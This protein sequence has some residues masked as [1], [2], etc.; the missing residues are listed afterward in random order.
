MPGGNI[1]KILL[2]GPYPPPHGGV[3]VHVYEARRQLRLA[4][5]ECRVVNV[6]P[7]APQS[8]DYV[9]IRGGL[10]LLFLLTRFARNGWT[11]HAHTN[12]HNRKSWLVALIAG[13][14]GRLGPGSLLTLHSGLAPAYIAKGRV[15]PR[16]LARSVCLLYRR[17]IAVAPEVRE[18]VLSLGLPAGRVGV[19]PAFLFTAPSG[20]EAPELQEVEGRKPL[21][22]ATLSFRPEYGFEL[23]VG[24]NGPSAR[25]ASG[26]RMPRHGKR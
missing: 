16:L 2:I 7:R 6:D 12:G 25:P 26:N 5:I 23:L 24:S 8:D 20:V 11:L 15:G 9:S 18:A 3:S 17:V 1:M 10:H 13:L 21:L 4:G 22:A 19:L 14:A